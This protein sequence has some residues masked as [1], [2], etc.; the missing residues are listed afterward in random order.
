MFS[1]LLTIS[2]LSVL[3][4]FWATGIGYLHT[5]YYPFVISNPDNIRFYLGIGAWC[6]AKGNVEFNQ[7]KL[8]KL[9]D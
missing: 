1:I 6:L 9:G 7:I 3:L 5:I 2:L 4:A 8:F